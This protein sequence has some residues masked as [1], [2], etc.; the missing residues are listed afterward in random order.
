MWTTNFNQFI[1]WKREIDFEKMKKRKIIGLSVYIIFEELIYFIEFVWTSL[2]ESMLNEFFL[3]SWR[4]IQSKS[5]RK[6]DFFGRVSIWIHLLV[7][8]SVFGRV[9]VHF[10]FSETPDRTDNFVLE[11]KWNKDIGYSFLSQF[12]IFSSS[13]NYKKVDLWIFLPL[14]LANP[15]DWLCFAVYKVMETCF[16]VDMYLLYHE[17][18]GKTL[19]TLLNLKA[20]RILVTLVN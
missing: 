5:L 11:V 19:T 9:D 3:S 2:L 8:R 10:P 16:F 4:L 15:S 17:T 7:W 14:S 18:S 20:R 6:L 12:F 1:A 13:P